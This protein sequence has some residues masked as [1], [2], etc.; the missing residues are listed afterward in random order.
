MPAI[1]PGLLPL[2]FA[3]L[4][5]LF[6]GLAW[7]AQTADEGRRLAARAYMRIAVIFAVVSVGLLLLGSV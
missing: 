6:A 1:P 2:L 4:A 5:L 3:V 7:R